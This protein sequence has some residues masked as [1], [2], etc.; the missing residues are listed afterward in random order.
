MDEAFGAAASSTIADTRFA[1]IDGFAAPGT[2]AKFSIVARL[3]PFLRRIS[4]R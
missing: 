3:V 4:R 1:R 2:Q